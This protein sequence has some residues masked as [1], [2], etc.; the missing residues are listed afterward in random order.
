MQEYAMVY[1]ECSCFGLVMSLQQGLMYQIPLFLVVNVLLTLGYYTMS[2]SR[3]LELLRVGGE[4][5]IIC[6]ILN[7]HNLKPSITHKMCICFMFGHSRKWDIF[8]FSQLLYIIILFVTF[9][10]STGH[11]YWAIL[12]GSHAKASRYYNIA[13]GCSSIWT[14]RWSHLV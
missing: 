7:I 3:W 10:K 9:Y 12:N 13:H 14:F 6:I 2:Y 5:W 8:I 1:S 4:N 11:M